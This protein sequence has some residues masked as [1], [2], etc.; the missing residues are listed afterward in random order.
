MS[1]A[2]PFRILNG[3]LQKDSYKS[4]TWFLTPLES[5]FSIVKLLVI[6][7]KNIFPFIQFHFRANKYAQW[8]EILK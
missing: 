8:R 1:N 5:Y 7:Q 2:S 3:I 4:I 6:F